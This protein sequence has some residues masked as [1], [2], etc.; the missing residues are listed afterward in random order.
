MAN[1]NTARAKRQ[2][3]CIVCGAQA[4]TKRALAA[5][6]T[7]RRR[8]RCRSMPPAARRVRGAYVCSAECF[9]AACKRNKLD[10]ALA[11]EARRAMITSAIAADVAAHER[12]ARERVEEWYMASMR[13]HE[14]AK[15][16]DM[17]SKDMLDQL[18]RDEDHRRK[19]MRACLPSAYVD[20]IRKNLS[21][22]IKRTRWRA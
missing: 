22:E 4:D 15:E 13:V 9:A 12:D 21:P 8:G 14:L 3:T 7:H 20:K 10:R 17:S 19:A 5:H 18:Q 6:R 1:G 2:R 16:F 11:R